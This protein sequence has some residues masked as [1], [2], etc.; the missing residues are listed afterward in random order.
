MTLSAE[1][2]RDAIKEVTPK[3]VVWVINLDSLTETMRLAYLLSG[4]LKAGDLVTLGGDLGSGKTSFARFLI[5]AL[6][7][8]ENHEVPSPTFTLMQL[9][10]GKNFPIVH[11]D[12]Y[13]INDPLELNELGW[14]EAADDALLVVEW[15]ER[16]GH[17]L[18]HDRLSLTF[19][20]EHEEE[21]EHRIGVLTG[22]GSWA[23]RLMQ[24]KQIHTLLFE[25]GW[26]EA[27][28]HLMQGDA[29]TRAYERLTLDNA[30]AIL[31]IA[32]SRPD[33]SHV[34]GG[35]SYSTI[36]KLA[37]SVHAFVA[38]CNGLR[39]RGFSAP[40]ILGQNLDAG[41][42][43]IEDFG[44]QFCYDDN[45]VIYERYCEAVNVLA[46]LHQGSEAEPFLPDVLA[47]TDKTN[48]RIPRFDLDAYLIEAE[49]VLDWYVPQD[50]RTNYTGSPRGKFIEAWTPLLNSVLKG[51]Q[52]WVLRDY[53]SPNLLWIPESKGIKCIGIIDFQDAVMGHPAYD[54]ASLLQDARLDVPPETE[55]KLLSHY[56]QVRRAADANFDVPNFVQAYSILGAQRATKILGIFA[57][58]NERDKKPAYLR[59]IPRIEAYL[60]RCLSDPILQ[61]V[62]D[63]YAH[64]LPNILVEPNADI[65]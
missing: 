35:K 45:G 61:P 65:S 51:E 16:A 3:E 14:D 60:R 32:P 8:D 6:T 9:Y 11:A 62:R 28:R 41:L 63:W 34:R 49:L 36:A 30:S 19:L 24:I 20:S 50:Q 37:T 58:L 64:Y 39:K 40:K 26:V 42:L 29:S 22:Y 7:D 1:I 56:A 5:R 55:L 23:K 33:G 44:N 57:R 2:S 10:Q 43:L 38:I 12:L 52:V 48:Y 54:V 13:R 59:H 25:T 31:M 15:A 53:H 27:E 46:K 17:I 47:I 21:P 18:A 4:S